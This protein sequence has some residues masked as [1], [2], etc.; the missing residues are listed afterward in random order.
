MR[1]VISFVFLALAAAP[2]AAQITETAYAP[3][4]LKSEVTVSGD[5]VRIG[6]LIENAG[7]PA[8]APIFR[9][10]DLGTTGAVPVRAVLEA[11]RPYGLIGVDVRGLTEV[12]VTHASRTLAPDAIE[13]RILAAL[14]ARYA[15]GKPDSLKVSFDQAVR[16]I[17]LSL[18]S[19]AEPTL[20][21]VSYDKAGGRFDVTF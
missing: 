12:A 7:A 19:A 17:E 2:A 4:R 11:V 3:A 16:P 10:P 5:I 14:T 13:Q 9:A 1:N 6:D 15:I 21:R 8:S 20:T 18:T